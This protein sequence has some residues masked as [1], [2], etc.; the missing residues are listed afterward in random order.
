MIDRFLSCYDVAVA[1]S[2]MIRTP[3]TE[4]YQTARHLNL[5]DSPIIRVLLGM[6]SLPQ[7]V[8]DRSAHGLAGRHRTPSTTFGL[9]DMV[10]YGWTLLGETPN[11]EVVFGQIG[12]P[13]KPVGASA[14][15]AFTPDAFP[16]FDRPGFAKIAFS[17]R[18]SSHGPASS[19]VTL[20]TRIAL[21]DSASRRN[22]RRYWRVVYPFVALIDRMALR[23]IVVERGRSAIGG[24]R[25]AEATG[26]AH[27]GWWGATEEERRLPL[28]GDELVPSAQ[29]E[30]THAVTIAASPEQ[31][32]PWL[33]QTGQGRAGFYSDSPFWDRC[34][35]WYYRRLSREQAGKAAVG[36]QVRVSDRV[37]PE[38]QNPQVGD[39]IADGPPGTAYYV[40]RHVTPAREF[41]VFTD[42]HLRH[43]LPARIRENPRIGL[44]GDISDDC[45]LTE[46][47]PGKTRLVRRMRLRCEPWPFR[48][49]AVPVVLIW[50]E[51]ITGRHFLRGVKRRAEA[52]AREVS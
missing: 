46:A 7:R 48:A 19:I 52:L 3:Q 40:V 2:G 43:L 31:V 30:I 29:L 25:T 10:R 20:E 17:L 28:L 16:G 47:E 32:W 36:Y 37:V 12:R 49:F 23:L 6:R 27:A 45:L 1:H 39:I 38:W 41:V 42:T 11:E 21:T 13:W 22:F 24:H 8:A 35:D 4:C 15:P 26:D 44:V 5:L 18:V 34:V 51:L 50:G 14:G 9:D 33:V